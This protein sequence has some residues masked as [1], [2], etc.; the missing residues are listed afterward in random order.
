VKSFRLSSYELVEIA[1]FYNEADINK[2]GKLQK[3]EIISSSAV[4]ENLITKD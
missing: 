4:N 1:K 2:D 3:E